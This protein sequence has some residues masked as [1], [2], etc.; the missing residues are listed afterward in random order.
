[1]RAHLLCPCIALIS[2][3]LPQLAELKALA[4]GLFGNDDEDDDD[5]AENGAEEA[6]EQQ[7]FVVGTRVRW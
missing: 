4:G 3:G 2:L 6:A 7:A 1:M 5:T